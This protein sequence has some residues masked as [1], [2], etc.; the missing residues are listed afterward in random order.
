MVAI[1]SFFLALLCLVSVAKADVDIIQSNKLNLQVAQN[2]VLF[3]AFVA[4]WCGH[5]TQF[6]PHL[7]DAAATLQEQAV[8]TTYRF[9]QVDADSNH[10]IPFGLHSPCSSH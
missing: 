6:K 4:S 1:T 9:A 3:V 7:H 8:S 2:E 10:G 5:C